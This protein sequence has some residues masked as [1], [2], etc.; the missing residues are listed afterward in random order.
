M[1]TC[2]PEN[3][4]YPGCFKGSVAKKLREIILS[5]CSC[6][7]SAWSSASPVQEMKG[8]VTSDPKEGHEKWSEAET[9][10]LWRKIEWVGVFLSLEQGR[11][12]GDLITAFQCTKSACKNDWEIVFYYTTRI[13]SDG[14]KSNG[15]KLIKGRFRL[16]RKKLFTMKVVRYRRKLFRI[17]VG[18]LSLEVFEVRLDMASNSERY[19]YTSQG[20]W[21]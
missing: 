7:I 6:E 9:S 20:I 12:Q 13:C 15:F 3:Q 2:S 14:T 4:L 8:H 17:V 5:P 1:C 21:K 16:E 10:L 18:D 19:P 11:H